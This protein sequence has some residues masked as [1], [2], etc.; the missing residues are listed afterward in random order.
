MNFDTRQYDIT[1]WHYFVI[2]RIYH[3]RDRIKKPGQQLCTNSAR[4]KVIRYLS[5][6]IIDRDVK[7]LS[8]NDRWWSNNT[9]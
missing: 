6:Q 5:G 3:P 8:F 2:C 7:I 9:L 4:A 1:R